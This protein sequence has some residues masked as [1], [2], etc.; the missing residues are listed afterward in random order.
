MD[1]KIILYSTG[2]PKC[3]VLK[4]KLTGRG[5]QFEENESV[6]TM[7]SMGIAEVPVLFVNGELLD[8]GKA[9]QWI[10]GYEGE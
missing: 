4:S 9:I 3:R 7:E 8:F 2:C 10:N 1:D 6:E 5:V